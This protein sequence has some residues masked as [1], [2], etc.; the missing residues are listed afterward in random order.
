MCQSKNKGGV[1]KTKE[2]DNADKSCLYICCLLIATHIQDQSRIQSFFN[3]LLEEFF[4]YKELL[5]KEYFTIK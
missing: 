3:Y 4:F 1:R 2:K 5:F